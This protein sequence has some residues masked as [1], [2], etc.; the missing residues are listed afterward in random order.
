M[1]TEEKSPVQNLFSGNFEE[2]DERVKSMMVKSSSFVV[3]R[4]ARTYADI[5]NVCGKEGLGSAIKH[6][7]EVNH[8]DYI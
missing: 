6:H 1:K 4:K 8:M 5:C 7:I 3:N 2:L